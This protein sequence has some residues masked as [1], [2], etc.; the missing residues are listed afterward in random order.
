MQIRSRLCSQECKSMS[1]TLRKQKET[2]K[3]SLMALLRFPKR[4]LYSE[5]QVPT[6]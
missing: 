4:E 3:V 2:T 1:C 5:D 6:D